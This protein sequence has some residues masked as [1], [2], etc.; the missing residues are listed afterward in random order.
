M[1]LSIL[2]DGSAQPRRQIMCICIYVLMYVLAYVQTF[3][4]RWRGAH[5]VAAFAVKQFILNLKY[6]ASA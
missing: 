2:S 5:H 6:E 3:Q 1:L 4:F